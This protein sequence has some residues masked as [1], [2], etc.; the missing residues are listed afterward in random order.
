MKWFLSLRVL[1]APHATASVFLAT[2]FLA[3]GLWYV[4]PLR[5]GG[6]AESSPQQ[7][8]PPGDTYESGYGRYTDE[9]K[10]GRDTWYFWTAGDEKF[11]RKM[12]AITQG[13]VD[14]L[15]Y[16][17]SRRHDRRFETLG[18]INYPK[19]EPATAPDKYG[20]WMDDCSAAEQI[21]QI[22]GKPVGIVGL[23]RFDNPAFDPAKWSLDA[24][25][26]DR[27]AVEP[28]Y[29]IGMACGY[30]HVGLNP[31]NP[32][33]DPNHATWANLHPTI[34][35]QYLEEGKLFSINMKPSDF[36]WH[37]ANRQPPGT[38]DTSRFAT[39]HI[40]NPNAINTIFNLAYRPTTPEK[41]R[42][43]SIREVNHILKDGA[44]SIGVAGASL[45]VYVNIGMC[46]DYWITLHDPVIGVKK[47]Q[48]PFDM[49]H[50]R[51]T[52]EDFRNTEA[53]MAGA[54]AFLKTL[55]PL[56]LADAPGGSAYVTKTSD[57]LRRGKVAFAD[58][59]ASCHSSKQPPQGTADVKAW[60]RTSVLADDFLTNNFLSD[61]KRYPVTLIGTNVARS[62]GSNATRGHIWDQFSSETYKSLPSAGALTGLYNPLNPRKPLSFTLPD[63]GRGYLRTASLTSIWAT[64]PYL[65]NNSLGIFNRDP[66]VQ[67]RLT[68]FLDGME[69]LLW[70][71]LRLGPQS[72]AVTTTDSTVTASGTTKVLHVPMGTPVDYIARVDPRQLAQM[73]AQFPGVD[74]LLKLTPDDVILAGL[75]KR[76]LAP[77]FIADHGHTFGSE[78][79][80]E[81]KWALIEFLKT[82]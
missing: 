9:Q 17:D 46:G 5:A 52:C 42:D 26:K 24:Y 23:R 68:A 65:H 70:P 14:L 66:S 54:E 73:V 75:I 8:Y 58:N 49:D 80:D 76:N 48:Q 18:A 19:C 6:P 1:R 20:L 47:A 15:M 78:L 69:K 53:R 55:T 79:S 57:V 67:G 34:G 2:V 28:P 16:V 32:P 37:V 41:M 81:D 36:R 60:Y 39:D 59:C 56:H 51:A 27:S 45:R 35:N 72:I 77:D 71:E 64:A 12:A 29:L 62:I 30:C 10:L 13:N 22:P 44:D 61:D 7:P 33:A 43:G 50:A 38:S 3:S 21:P 82:F 63:G 74:L 31:L 40:N 25:L 4:T 11:W